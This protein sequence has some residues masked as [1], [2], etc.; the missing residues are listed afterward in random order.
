MKQLDSDIISKNCP[1]VSI[2]VPVYKVEEH[3]SKCAESLMQQTYENLEFLFVNDGTPDNSI[4]VLL[5]VIEKYPKQKNKVNIVNLQIN[6]GVANARN[7]AVE[8]C[9]GDYIFWCDSDDWLEK[10]TIEILVNE[11]IKTNSDIVTCNTII[12]SGKKTYLSN[13]PEEPLEYIL[14]ETHIYRIWGRLI[15][16]S[17]YI[18]NNIRT[19]DAIAEDL[20]TTPKLLYYA[21]KHHNVN[22]GLYHYNLN[23][24]NSIG[25]SANNIDWYRQLLKSYYIFYNFIIGRN[26]EKYTDLINRGK[27]DFLL[28]YMKSCVLTSQKEAFQLLRQELI[29]H[30]KDYP[31]YKRHGF[32]HLLKKNYTISHFVI[33]YLQRKH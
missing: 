20:Q 26:N 6:K 8:H 17:L 3:I 30:E 22:K 28:Y 16:K 32:K 29:K 18:D 15:K 11:L 31:R 19:Q 12:H 1:K 27:N 14:K 7:I 10:D 23:N 33:K 21:K 2:C 4:K 5:D 25:K 9:I 13:L 24:Q